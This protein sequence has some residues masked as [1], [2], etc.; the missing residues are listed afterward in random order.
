MA[1]SSSGLWQGSTIEH[2]LRPVAHPVFTARARTAECLPG[3]SAPSLIHAP[4]LTGPPRS[5]AA[6]GRGCGAARAVSVQTGSST[7]GVESRS[8]ITFFDGMDM[9]EP[10][11]H[12]HLRDLSRSAPAAGK[13]PFACGD[14]GPGDD[15][16]PAYTRSRVTVDSLPAARPSKLPPRDDR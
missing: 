9:T 15:I 14:I 4:S 7:T 6:G 5:P 16:I 2:R 12:L 1:D 11:H 10:S 8:G 3:N 13:V